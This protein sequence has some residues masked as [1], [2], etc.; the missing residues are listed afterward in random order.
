MRL[1]GGNTR[2]AVG[3]TMRTLLAPVAGVVF[4][5]LVVIAFLV[6]TTARSLDRRAEADSRHLATVAMRQIMDNLRRGTLDYTWWDESVQRVVLTLDREWTA[7]LWGYYQENFRLIDA[8]MAL[9]PEGEVIMV[10]RRGRPRFGGERLAFEPGLE[11]M[12][13]QALAASVTDP[14][15][16]LAWMM[17]EGEVYAV[18]VGA[19]TPSDPIWARTMGPQRGIGVF[20]RH[21]APVLDRRTEQDFLLYGLHIVGADDAAGPGRLALAGPEGETVAA[22]AWEPERPGRALALGVLLPITLGLLLAVP[23]LTAFIARAQRIVQERTRLGES[24]K[25]ERELGVLRSRF[26]SMVSHEFRTPL[27]AIMASSEMLQHYSDRLDAEQRIA[28]TAAI[29]REVERLSALIDEVIAMGRAD[30]SGFEYNPEPVDLG[31]LVREVADRALLSASRSH[32]ITVRG[33]ETC[34]SVD[35]DR[36]LLDHILANVIGN[37][38]K[39]SPSGEPIDIALRCS[40]ER[41]TIEVTDRGIGIPEEDIERIGTPFFRGDNAGSIGGTGLGLAI[42]LRAA[43]R[44]GGGLHILSE[45]GRGTKVVIELQLSAR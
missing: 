28:E 33:G 35:A 21:L 18:A 23:L 2:E 27:T 43:Q 30:E 36:K 26:I 19:I 40:G 37:A 29:A 17:L 41:A 45:V 5:A 11:G 24:L 3:G 34:G 32:E 12:I 13:E 7:H 6:A 20:A 8:V 42:A 39:Y 14:Q 31:Q 22:L 16:V 9:D 4:V 38:V 1:G 10:W 25:R 15:P 44:H